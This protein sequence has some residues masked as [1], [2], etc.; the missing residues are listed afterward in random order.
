MG[1]RLVGFVKSSLAFRQ[2][3]MCVT[4]CFTRWST[5][6]AFC[7]IDGPGTGACLPGWWE[8]FKSFFSAFHFFAGGRHPLRELHLF[9]CL[10]IC[11]FMVYILYIL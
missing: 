10:F 6:A 4:T 5:F 2:A 11:M 7:P 9:I 3:T 8:A 1:L